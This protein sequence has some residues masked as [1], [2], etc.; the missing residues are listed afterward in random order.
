LLIPI[1]GAISSR[2][3]E[4]TARVARFFAKYTKD[5][6]GL[7]DGWP[8]PPPS[9]PAVHVCEYA[10]TKRGAW[11]KKEWCGSPFPGDTDWMRAKISAIRDGVTSADF[12]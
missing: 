9:N 12:F 10:K 1:E 6:D 11:K 3:A 5:H 4:P 7:Q 2:F 8:E